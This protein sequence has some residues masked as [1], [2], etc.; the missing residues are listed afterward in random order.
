MYLSSRQSLLRPNLMLTSQDRDSDKVTMFSSESLSEQY[1]CGDL[2]TGTLKV[3]E[4][5]PV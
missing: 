3:A 4:K 2:G 1:K 5:C